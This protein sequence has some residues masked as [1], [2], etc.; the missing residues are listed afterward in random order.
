MLSVI[1]YMKFKYNLK[2]TA[3]YI[4]SSK[5]TSADMLSRGE[6]PGWLKRRGAE[7][8]IDIGEIDKILIN[9]IAFWTEVLSL[10]ACSRS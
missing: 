4:E 10:Q 8:S 3:Y 2:I 5:N 9:P 6:I 1:E 7:C